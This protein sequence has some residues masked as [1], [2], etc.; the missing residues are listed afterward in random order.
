MNQIHVRSFLFS[1]FF[2]DFF[3]ACISLSFNHHTDYLN[4]FLKRV[5]VSP[6][7]CH[8]YSPFVL[9]PAR[10]LLDILVLQ[11]SIVPWYSVSFP[12]YA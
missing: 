9:I 4:I 12:L 7:C 5:R 6:D 8:P 1:F 3:F 11:L 10:S 2:L